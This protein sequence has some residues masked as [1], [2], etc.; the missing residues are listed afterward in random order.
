[1]TALDD[2][3]PNNNLFIDKNGNPNIVSR[4]S[5]TAKDWLISDTFTINSA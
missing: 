3:N 2:K 5:K 4:G 1:M